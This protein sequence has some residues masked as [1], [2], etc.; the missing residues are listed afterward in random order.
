MH[1]SRLRAAV[2]AACLPLSSLALGG[3]PAWATPATGPASLPVGAA[4]AGFYPFGSYAIT[5]GRLSLPPHNTADVNQARV[6][7]APAAGHFSVDMAKGFA[8]W[9]SACSLTDVAQLKV[10]FP[11]VTGLEGA[12][13]GAKGQEMVSGKMT[14]RDVQCRYKLKT[15]FQ[16]S[17]YGT[18]FSWVEVDIEQVGPASP[19]AWAQGLSQQR[20]MAKKYPAQ[21]AYY[22]ALK[23]GTR[24]FWDGNEL[25]CLKGDFNYWVLG[26]KVT[27]GT[28]TSTDGMVWID[29]LL[30]P[31]A[32]KVATEV[33]TKA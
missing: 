7:A 1:K 17:G 6:A 5:G 16:P 26:Q 20:G 9:P 2:A 15:T 4:P 30:L 24:C 29:Q 25:Q 13:V 18:V 33:T 3:S 27:G 22:P 31:L 32:E 8:A 28:N 19:Q 21:F 14:P 23:G 11:A 12:P 10:L